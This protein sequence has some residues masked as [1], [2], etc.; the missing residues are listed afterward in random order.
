MFALAPRGA[1]RARPACG[2]ALAFLVLL[3][4][5]AAC[6]GAS[7]AEPVAAQVPEPTVHEAGGRAFGTTWSA[8]WVQPE[9]SPVEPTAVVAAIEAALA[10]VDRGMSTWRED[11]EL[12]RARASRGPLPI[13]E[14]TAS[15]VREALALA[16]ATGGAFDPTVQPLM[17]LWGFHGTSRSSWPTAEELAAA[18]EKVGWRKVQLDRDPA[19]Q[20]TLD[21][22][23]TA[24]D[25]SA[26]AKGHGVDRALHAMAALG[27]DAAFIE[28]GGEVRAVG[29]A[30]SGRGWR[31]GVN[32]PDP[33][34]APTDL[35]LVIGFTNAAV[36]TSGN[37]RNAVVLDGRTVGH[38][39]DPRTGEPAVTSV[40]SATVVAPDCRLADGVA[41]ALMVMSYEDGARWVEALPDVQAAWLLAGDGGLDLR[42]SSGLSLDSSAP[43]SVDVVHDAVRPPPLP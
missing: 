23:G 28:I 27:I 21:V 4:G 32:L 22:G 31:V 10:E 26:I 1:P 15:V 13:S 38:T 34:A 40:R 30:P 5:A 20:P 41:T 6:S 18:R 33:A 39:M 17:E 11:S 9:R 29:E 16:Q 25:L 35:A 12:S 42:V 7:D 37:Y 24:L 36:A 19:G 43:R 2:R 14:D 3:F 8:R